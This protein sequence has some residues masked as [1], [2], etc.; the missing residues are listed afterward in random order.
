MVLYILGDSKFHNSSKFITF[1]VLSYGT[2]DLIKYC[3]SYLSLTLLWQE[4]G[5]VLLCYCRGV[6]RNPSSPVRFS[7]RPR[8]RLLNT[9]GQG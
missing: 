2:L 9:A 4:A 8:E 1:I 6:G 7:S 5:R 3:F